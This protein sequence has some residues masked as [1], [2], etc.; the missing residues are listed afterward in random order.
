MLFEGEYKPEVLATFNTAPLPV[1]R[2]ALS[3][4]HHY[5]LTGFFVLCLVRLETVPCADQLHK[6]KAFNSN[7]VSEPH[8][9]LGHFP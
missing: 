4:T 1:L 9:E 3:P 2:V 8:I 5:F 6:E 7:V